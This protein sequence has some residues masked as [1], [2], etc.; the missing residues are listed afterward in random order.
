MSAIKTGAARIALR[1]ARTGS[2]LRIVPVGLTYHQ[3]NR[4]HSRVLIQ[5]GTPVPVTAP[6][7][8]SGEAEIE[9]VRGLT[10][11]V[12]DAMKDVTLNLQE[13]AD[14][15]LIE[16]AEQLYALRIGEKDHD[17]DRIR[18]FARG[19]D[20][21][22]RERPEL[23][24]TMRDEVMAFRQRLQMVFADAK[25]LSLQYRRPLVARFVAR[26][27]LSLLV[28]FPLFLFGIALFVVPFMAVRIL[29]RVVPLEADRIATLKFVSALVVTPA[30][31]AVL[32]WVAWR[33]FGTGA[34][35][36]TLLGALPLA[37]FTRY[38]FERWRGVLRD[39]ATFFT[40][41][42][43]SRLKA[44][45]LVEGERL[46]QEIETLAVEL[47]PRTMTSKPT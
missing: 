4:F 15:A 30:W 37:F 31:Q 29:S 46:A 27:L 8:L 11:Q 40:L 2:P 26:N 9:W 6:S 18:R 5:V 10:E 13:W 39:L 20:I 17:P 12:A 28:G 16:T 14:L 35:V 24:E 1:V 7:D 19:V 21:L 45:L 41:G 43:R 47:K 42:S 22:R 44:R 33:W 23:F 36:V 38:F 34:M 32:G 25:D 3:K